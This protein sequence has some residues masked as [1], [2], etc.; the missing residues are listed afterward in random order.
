MHIFALLYDASIYLYVFAHLITLHEWVFACM[1]VCLLQLMFMFAFV[2]LVF[3]F[4][5]FCVSVFVY[6]CMHNFIIVCMCASAL[7][8]L[9]VSV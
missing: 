3:A 9:V 4:V 7:V 5:S 8:S 6:M 1:Y 2:L